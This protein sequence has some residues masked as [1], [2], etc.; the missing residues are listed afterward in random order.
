YLGMHN[1]VSFLITDEMNLYEQQSSFNPNMPLR[2]LQYI[3]NLY[4]KYVTEHK[5]NK[6]GSELLEL[7]V[8]KLVVFYNGS[9][10][11]ENELYLK[12]SS[13]FPEGAESDVEVRVRMINVNYGKNPELLEKCK[14]LGEYAWL[15]DRIRKIKSEQ[16]S[17]NPIESIIDRAI[18]EIPEG[19]VLRPFLMVHRS[20]VKGMLLTEYNEVETMQLFREDG[21]R[22]GHQEG[23]KDGRKE[24]ILD[25]IQTFL[26]NGGTE[27][28][29]KT[30][31]NVTDKQ[32]EEAKKLIK[33]ENKEK[34]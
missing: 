28:M 20:E 30:M 7:P 9:R 1:D 19:F 26:K 11:T 17:G 4:E 14:P 22:E 29:A 10:D 15:V 6:Y 33:S 3:G 34:Q 24:G 27:E 23:L 8:P 21:R 12:L 32:I 18:T 2:M 25:A 31:L 13:S 5:L 16:N